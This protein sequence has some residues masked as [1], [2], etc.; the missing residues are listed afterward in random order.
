MHTIEIALTANRNLAAL[1]ALIEHAITEAGLL[2]DRR[3]LR[4]YPRATHWHIR[5]PGTQ[6]TLELTY[7]PRAERL[8][9]AVHAN[10]RAE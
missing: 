4:S 10:R 1:L 5:R 9:F 3:E 6:G 7:W 2:G 8:W